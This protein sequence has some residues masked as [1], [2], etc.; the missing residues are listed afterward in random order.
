MSLPS[1]SSER[2]LPFDFFPFP[3]TGFSSCHAFF[4]SFVL[5]LCTRWF[6]LSIARCASD[7]DEF[8]PAE[9]F[10]PSLRMV[11][12]EGALG[13]CFP[14]LWT[15]DP[16][17]EVSGEAS[18]GGGGTGILLS[19]VTGRVRLEGVERPNAGADLTEFSVFVLLLVA[20]LNGRA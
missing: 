19:R 20:A 16:M 14:L 7:V 1:S 12:R 5:K 17:L 15:L 9:W 10:P 13:L 6:K 4:G 3:L 18:L 2:P 8:D 11:T